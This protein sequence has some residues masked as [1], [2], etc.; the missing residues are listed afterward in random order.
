[1]AA[2]IQNPVIVI[3]GITGTDLRD[4]YQVS[5]DTVWEL[6]IVPSQQFDRI[7]LHPDD[8]QFERVEPARV[9]PNRVSDLGYQEF[10]EE[11]RHD[12]SPT[13]DQPTPVFPFAY[14]W[15]QP[16]KS[17]EAQLE[18]FIGEVIQRTR[19]LRHYHDAGYG[20]DLDDARVDLVGHSMGGL[21]IAGYLA[22]RG[23][24]SRVGRV[25]T[26]GSPF[27]GSLESIVK[28]ATGLT[29]LGGGRPSSR[30]R[31]T[32]RVTPGVYHLVPS[33]PNA[34]VPS[35]A[36][37]VTDL[38]ELKA[39]QPSIVETIAEYI[40]MFGL[41]PS[42]NNT[43]KA[44]LVLGKMLADAKAHRAKME[45]LQLA[46]CG[47]TSS[48]WLCVVGVGERTRVR[49]PVNLQDGKPRFEISTSDMIDNFGS[50]PGSALTGDGTVPFLGA[51]N[52]FVSADR[53]VCISPQDFGLFELGDRAAN[54]AVGLHGMLP[55]MSVVQQLVVSHF[56]QTIRPRAF[57]RRAPGVASWQPPIKGLPEK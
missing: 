21:V 43:K 57:G 15:R 42:R 11:L 36:S 48:D 41:D 32:A 55:R 46:D 35:A 27:R 37:L 20:D 25:A 22:D 24:R 6:G 49:M 56:T 1:M 5:P 19:L 40:R 16:L 13:A 8:L 44:E 26:L 7:A 31:E 52:A 54:L 3:P 51:C 4:E 28:V 39:W 2:K 30:D 29:T 17:T 9:R 18:A 33:F 53:Y 10:I 50:V 38:F 47:L 34:L 23:V 14:D 12:L 45:K